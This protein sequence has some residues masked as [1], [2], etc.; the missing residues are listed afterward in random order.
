MRAIIM[1][2][3][4]REAILTMTTKS[5]REKRWF[6][7]IFGCFF[8]IL[9]LFSSVTPAFAEPEAGTT[10]TTETTEVTAPVTPD[11]TGVTNDTNNAD[12]TND[13]TSELTEEKDKKEKGVSCEESLGSLGWLVCPTTGKIAEAVDWLYEKIKGILVINPVEMKDGAPIYE[14]WKYFRG[15]TNILFI[16]FLLV[17]VYSQLTGV[18]ITNYGVKKALPKLIVAAV[19]VNLSFVVC[20]LA[21]DLSNII[22]GSLRGVFETIETSTMASMEVGAAAGPAAVSTSDMYTALSDGTMLTIGGTTVALETG[23]IWML[24]PTVLGAVVAVAVGLITIAMRQAVV[25][26]LIM[27]APLAMVAYILPNTEVWFKKWKDL[28]F[29][30][31]VFYPMFSLLFGASS[32]A[33]WAIIVS[34]TDGFGVMLGVAVQIFPLFFS[35]SLMKMSGTILGTINTKLAGIMARPVEANRR[36]AES[37]REY[38]RQKQLAREDAFT[39]SLRLRQFLSDRKIA[40]EEATGEKA[41]LV[42]TRGL[43]YKARSNYKRGDVNGTLSSRGADKYEDQA[44]MTEYQ[45]VIERDKANYNKGFAYRAKEGTFERARLNAL[46]I[47]NMN[48]ADRLR[49]EVERGAQIDY[50]NM[51]GF[52]D[53]I[54]GAKDAHLDDEAMREGN[55]LHQF[56]PEKFTEANLERYK[57]MKEVMEGKDLDTNYIL[58]GAAHSFNAQAQ[59]V[60]G[61]FNDLFSYTAPTQDLVNILNEMTKSA[62]S[63]AYI[64]PIIAG[65]RTLNMRGD[66]DLVMRQLKS[67]LDDKK[68]DLGTYASQSLANFLMFDVKGSDPFLRRFGKYINLETAAMFNENDPEKRRTRKDISFDEYVNSE[69]VDYDADGNVILDENGQPKI[70]KSKRGAAELMKGTSYKDMER[71][72]IG[73]MNEA[74]R[75]ASMDEDENGNKTFNYEKFKKNQKAIWDAIMPNVIGDQYSFLSGSEQISSLGKGI[76]GMDVKKHRFDWEGIFGKEIAKQLTPEQKKDYLEFM[77]ERTK[78]FLGGQVPSQIARTKTD[79]LEAVRNQYAFKDAMDNDSEFFEKASKS[80]F[81][82]SKDDYKQFEQE[83]MD[84]IRKEF[85]GS[86]KEDALKGFVKMHHKGYQGEAKDGLIQLLNPDELYKKYFGGV[87]ENDNRDRRKDGMEDDDEDEGMRV[88]F[89]E[90]GNGGTENSDIRNEIESVYENYR[91][92]SGADVEHFWNEIKPLIANMPG[93]GAAV[94]IDEIDHSLEQ[95][96]SVVSLYAYIVNRL[97]GGLE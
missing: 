39:P 24:I 26:L 45:G 62:D 73:E 4:D 60:R 1:L 46:D 25:A 55:L 70:R 3:L 36:W 23:A 13:T 68:V 15:V 30:M 7:A 63:V 51:K 58:A 27:I 33:G 65:M 42:K 48:A 50:N 21:V 88:E 8:G 2:S 92:A 31:L 9:M 64:D 61:K 22:G 90:V 53:R 76:T 35:W 66:T 18:G 77:N 41:A 10:E 91:G 12:E 44:R 81:E 57:T 5:I 79:I 56:H 52:Y 93:V 89:G 96:T 14:I 87:S 29:R 16:V 11:D 71:T 49:M 67:V 32:L 82:M 17:V 84:K 19:L 20:S 43:A 28:L 69:Y 83:R 80:G 47:R 59:V 6:K 37:H 72:A 54:A 75:E 94:F 38:T 34:A 86:Y 74:I 97:F 85:V 95:Y 78:I 40:R